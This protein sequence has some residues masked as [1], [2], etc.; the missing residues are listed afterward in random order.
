MSKLE[1]FKTRKESL[2]PTMGV[3]LNQ[4]QE[5]WVYNV[6][7]K[8][9]TNY[10]NWIQLGIKCP[11]CNWQGVEKI[12]GDGMK[13]HIVEKDGQKLVSELY[14]ARCPY[15]KNAWEIDTTRPYDPKTLAMSIN[16][17]LNDGISEVD[18]EIKEKND[19][20]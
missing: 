11:K 18:E 15:C 8:H 14:F 16:D 10:N 17:D 2:L 9:N 5:I 20:I 6:D 19:E 7:L 12:I 3:Y 4:Y 13:S 1:G